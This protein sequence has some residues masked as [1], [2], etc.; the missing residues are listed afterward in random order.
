MVGVGSP[1]PG[2]G[3]GSEDVSEAEAMC[4]CVHTYPH[5]GWLI[6]D[7]SQLIHRDGGRG[8]AEVTVAERAWRMFT[9]FRLRCAST[10][11]C[12]VILMQFL[13][14]VEWSLPPS[15][16]P[17]WVGPRPASSLSR[18]MATWRASATSFLPR[19]P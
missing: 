8:Y 17:I 4:R 15:S 10:S 6:H 14:T 18:Y 1:L 2:R 16:L 12:S 3:G 7:N 11:S 5:G 13:I 9:T 19:G